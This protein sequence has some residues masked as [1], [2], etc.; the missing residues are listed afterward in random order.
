MEVY[1]ESEVKA[2][3]AKQWLQAAEASEA[4]TALNEITVA[5]IEKDF[6]STYGEVQEDWHRRTKEAI[7]YIKQ[8]LKLEEFACEDVLRQIATKRAVDGNLTSS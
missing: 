7:E 4:L 1:Q 2:A 5:S 3:T 6:P 8:C